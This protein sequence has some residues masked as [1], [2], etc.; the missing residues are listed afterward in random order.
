MP[1]TGVQT[2]ALPIF[3]KKAIE[4]ALGH[5]LNYEEEEYA[6]YYYESGYEGLPDFGSERM[7]DFCQMLYGG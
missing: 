5:P 2:C 1:V 3:N 4:K 6:I 7:S